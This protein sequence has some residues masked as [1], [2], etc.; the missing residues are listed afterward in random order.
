MDTRNDHLIP[1][2]IVSFRV[3]ISRL[4]IGLVQ[5]LLLYFLYHALTSH[6]W[7][8]AQGMI[9]AP[10]LLA[11]VLVP[12]L[13]I[14]S[15]GH[16]K[17][18]QVVVWTLLATVL[19][20]GLA[21]HDIG[22]AAFHQSMMDRDG[23]N[24]ANI[25]PS[26][27]L[28]FL[29]TAGLFIAHALVQAGGQEGRRIA[30]Y[31][32]YFETSWTLLVQLKFALFF[33]CVLWMILWM[34]ASL[35]MLVKLDFLRELLTKSWFAI[36]VSAFAFSCALH[37]TDVR[38]AIVRGIRTL[39]LML[40]SWMLPVTVLIVAGFLFNLPWTGLTPLWGTK[41]ATSVLLG[42]TAVLVVLINAAFQ[43]GETGGSVARIVRMSANAGA[44]LLLPMTVIAIYALM[45]RVGDYGWTV[46]RIVA[47]ACLLVASVYALGYAWAA[48]PFHHGAWLMPVARI[49]VINALLILGLMVA[50]LSPL[51]DPARLSVNDQ[52]AR[53]DSGKISAGKFDFDYLK[54]KGARYGMAALNELAHRTGGADAARVREL[55]E[56]AIKKPGLFAP[57]LPLQENEIAG[58]LHA[59]PK[60]ATI[61][62][63]VLQQKWAIGEHS[64][65][66]PACLKSRGEA[67]D[68]YAINLSGESRRELLVIDEHPQQDPAVLAEAADGSWFL[69]GTLQGEAARCAPVLQKMREGDFKLAV[70]R[71]K[72][73][74]VAGEHLAFVTPVGKR[75]CEVNG[76]ANGNASGK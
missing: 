3:A 45:L 27:L 21:M 59:W 11:G 24:N 39:L 67:C 16:L 55:A 26:A 52:L 42:A 76:N 9:F 17:Q 61:P 70:P 6:S 12:P 23:V 2:A 69:A 7:P 68:V 46:D 29:A 28:F 4:L 66:L 56:R 13:L 31:P 25:L 37:L 44:L 20:A 22:R 34:G 65:Q 1:E 35:F 15:L 41:H 14:T 30:S 19:L 43:N 58:N 62:E 73:V 53:L 33:V 8:S 63:K 54:F 5:G 51:A 47:A 72:D 60:G 18:R 10:L 36:P 64:W 75:H 38:P 49:N 71:A 32:T 57:A 50:L 48:L 40:L 74:E